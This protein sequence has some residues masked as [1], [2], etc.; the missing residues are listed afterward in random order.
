MDITTILGLVLGLGG[1]LLGATL[2]GLPL[3][4][5]I[6]PTAAM[7]VFGGTFGATL[8]QFPLGFV[9]KSLKLI[10]RIFF[11]KGGDPGPVIRKI[12]DLSKTSRKEG[13]LKLEAHLEDPEIKADPFFARGVRMVMDGTEITKV[14]EALEVEA[15]YIEEEEGVAFK[16]YESAGGYAPTIGILGAVLGLIHVMSNM[17]DPNKLAEGIATAFV[18]TVYGVGSANL[19]YLPIGGKLKLKART[20][21]KIREIIVDGLVGIGQ[22]ENPGMIEERLL[23]FLNEA[24]RVKY[25]QTYR[26]GK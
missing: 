4:T 1:I 18:A 21:G 19:V 11:S 2:E 17:G 5:I 6:Q 16:V 7:I 9:M 10:P 20:E 13:L 22:G 12:Q 23:G 15:H 14:R 8:L 25:E 3:S 26:K 24:E